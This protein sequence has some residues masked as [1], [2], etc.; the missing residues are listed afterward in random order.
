MM[1]MVLDTTFDLGHGKVAVESLPILV[2]LD[3][4]HLMKEKSND[5]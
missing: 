3:S 2:L 5:N 4:G 1:N